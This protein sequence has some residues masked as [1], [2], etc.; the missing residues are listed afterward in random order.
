MVQRWP[1]RVPIPGTDAP[2]PV[3][4]AAVRRGTA[5]YRHAHHRH[6]LPHCLRRDRLHPGAVRRGENR[7]AEHDRPLFDRG[8]RRRRGLRR[9][10][11]RGRGDDH[12][13][14]GN[15]GP[16]HGRNADGP[17]DHH[18]QHLVHAGCRARGLDL[19]GDHAGRVLSPDGIERAADCRFHLALGAG[20][21]RDFGP[22]GR[23]SGRGG[24]PGL[25]RF[26]DQERVR[27]GRCHPLS[28]TGRKAA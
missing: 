6:L 7:A 5:D 18:L 1:V 16:A 13:V 19:H 3:R 4:H 22:H 27:A 9:T 2:P 17:H 8:R 11:R 28:R 14:P 23:D 15:E 24:L 21:A 26:L 10:G 12:A 20:D 25:P